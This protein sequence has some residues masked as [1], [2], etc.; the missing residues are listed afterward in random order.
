MNR[1]TSCCFTGHRNIDG[2][3]KE[4]LTDAVKRVI[5]EL[6]NKGYT[7]F[8]CGGALG[9][10]TLCEEAV[11]ELKD[12]LGIRLI[13]ILPCVN[14]DKDWSKE[15]KD[16]YN[17]I[18]TYADEI[19]YT[20][21]MYHIGCMHKRDRELVDSSSVCVCYKIKDKGG[22][23]YTVDYAEKQGLEIVNLANRQ[24]EL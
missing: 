17:R 6:S 21:D 12:T 3:Q 23:K 2:N 7:D 13:L 10:D 15:N 4:Y 16:R 8:C 18:K 11:I 19:R 5:V 9:F 24:M 1:E 20:D 14:Q 22:T